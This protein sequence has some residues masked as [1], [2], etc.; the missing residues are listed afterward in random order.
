MNL[1]IINSSNIPKVWAEVKPLIDKALA[2]A[3]GEMDSSDVLT[4]LFK[5]QQILWVGFKDDGI[6]CAG[7][8][9]IVNY[10]KKRVL[11]IITFATKSGH[12]YDLW[13]DFIHTLEG[14]GQMCGCVSIEAWVRKGLARK[15]KW[16]NEYSIITK[17]I[18][19]GD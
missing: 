6:F 14:F 3:D 18:I 19:P 13:K 16:N 5:E 15:L 1:S 8:T 7:T 2:H 4:L 9:E 10:P 12:D 17:P 11:R